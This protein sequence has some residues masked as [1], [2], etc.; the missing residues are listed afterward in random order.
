MARCWVLAAGGRVGRKRLARGE[1]KGALPQAFA[2]DKPPERRLP[3]PRSARAALRRERVRYLHPNQ[4]AARL[5]RRGSLYRHV[6][7]GPAAPGHRNAAVRRSARKGMV[8]VADTGRPLGVAR[9]PRRLAW[10]AAQWAAL[11][12]CFSHGGTG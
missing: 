11:L 7:S 10:T 2:R 12:A 3:V 6:R 5:R 4:P 1:S 8:L 9:R